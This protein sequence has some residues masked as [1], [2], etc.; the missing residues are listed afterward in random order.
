MTQA[1]PGQTSDATSTSASDSDRVRRFERDV[2]GL[3]VPVAAAQRES[4]LL[5]G[6]VVLVVAGVAAVF[7]GYWGASGTTNVAD[8]MPY[9]LSGGAIGLA[10]VIVGSV[11]IGRYSMAKLF[12]FWLAL[13]VAEHRSQTDR[14]IE[15]L[16]DDRKGA[17]GR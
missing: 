13:L 5:W 14:L 17:S 4:W 10:L 6:G 9:M 3:D 12:R 2:A 16:S 11:L 15:A 1:V 7:V 8:Q